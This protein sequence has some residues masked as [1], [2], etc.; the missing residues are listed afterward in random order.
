MTHGSCIWELPGLSLPVC[1]VQK[2][3]ET[4]RKAREVGERE[5]R[6]YSDATAGLPV[7][8]VTAER[9]VHP[10]PV[11]HQSR[12]SVYQDLRLLGVGEP[13]EDKGQALGYRPELM[14]LL[15]AAHLQHGVCQ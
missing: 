3:M 5:E 1:R 8:R 13:Q 10:H 7:P 6:S 14:A 11:R 12:H 9:E 15:L 4:W 2:E